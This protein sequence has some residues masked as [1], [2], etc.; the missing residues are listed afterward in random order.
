MVIGF[1]E[2]KG[3]FT[4][5]LFEKM[6][7]KDIPECQIYEARG[8]DCKKNIYIFFAGFLHCPG[9]TCDRSFMLSLDDH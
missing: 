7:E 4:D 6:T 9:R 3:G 1:S 8:T 2:K 5:V